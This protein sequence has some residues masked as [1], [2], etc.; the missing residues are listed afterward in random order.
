[1]SHKPTEAKFRKIPAG[2]RK[3]S[4][5]RKRGTTRKDPVKFFPTPEPTHNFKA[6]LLAVASKLR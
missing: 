1:M 3:T 2:N 6:Q 5:F 4:R